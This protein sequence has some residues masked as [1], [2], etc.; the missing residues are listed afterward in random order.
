MS[1]SYIQSGQFTKVVSAITG[2]TLFR[3]DSSDKFLLSPES[4]LARLRAVCNREVL[5]WTCEEYWPKLS[6]TPYGTACNRL[7]GI[8]SKPEFIDGFNGLIEMIVAN[9]VRDSKLMTKTGLKRRVVELS[10]ALWEAGQM[11]LPPQWKFGDGDRMAV[12]LNRLRLGKEF[13]WIFEIERASRATTVQSRRRAALNVWRLGT[14]AAGVREVGD[15]LPMTVRLDAISGSRGLAAASIIPLLIVQR[16]IYGDSATFKDHDWG[17]GRGKHR[18]HSDFSRLAGGDEAL[19]EWRSIFEAWFGGE[20]TSGLEAKRSALSTFFRYLLA[21]AQVTRNP[22]EFVSRTYI[23]PVPFEAWIDDQGYEEGTSA[24]RIGQVA[25]FF[26]WYVDTHLA[27]EDDFGR[28]VRNPS[29][30]NPIARRKEA[31]KRAET[32]REALPIR[33][34]RELIHIITENDYAWAK[35][36]KEDY[37]SRYDTETQ[38]WKLFWCPV[39]AYALLIKLY[40]PLRTFQV[41]MLDSG[42]GDSVL[43][44]DG[45]WEKNT[46]DLA[47]HGRRSVQRGFLRQFKDNGT[48]GEFV[49]FYVN[50][51]K[52]ADRFKDADARGYEMPW[53]HDEVITLV[54]DLAAWQVKYNPLNKPTRWSDVTLPSVR[55]SYTPTQLAARGEACFLF[56]DPK[57]GDSFLPVQPG[58]I[59]Q[60]WYKLMDELERRVA[61]RGE[62]LP[63][64]HPIRFIEKRGETGLPMV[65][66][67]DLHSL[68]VSILTAL[69]VEGAVP[70]SVL[71]KCVAGHA[72][73][74]MTLYY[75][76]QGP[77]YIS[78][79]LAEAQARIQAKEQENFVRFLQD[80]DLKNVDSVVAY[81]DRVALDSISGRNATGWMVDDLGICPVGGSL[82]HQGGPKLTGENGRIDFQPTPG[83]P[84]NCVRCRFFLSGP[85]FL[86]G[87]VAHFNSIGVELMESSDRLRK[88]DADIGSI[89]DVMYAP[90]QHLAH[91]RIKLDALYGRRE[92]AMSEL[93]DVA[94]NW[95]AT[96]ML[97]ERSRSLLEKER[98]QA[99]CQGTVRLVA[100]GEESDI[101]TALVESSSFALY[102]SV[103]QHA[104]IYPARSAPIAI[105][106]RG[107]L[108][109]AMLARNDKQ[110]IFS[111]LT[112]DE[113]LLVGNAMVAFLRARIGERETERL[114]AGTRMLESAGLG[115]DLD[116]MLVSQLGVP[117]KLLAVRGKKSVGNESKGCPE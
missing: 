28:P 13:S 72:S 35:G 75:L 9:H 30:F 12:E 44:R 36:F 23:C 6:G 39:R 65:A 111:S 107:R 109:D 106:R 46:T 40:L 18:A 95:H 100:G 115:P 49:G 90:G 16:Q 71:S 74:L 116:V 60:Y 3:N 43:Y 25:G 85:A 37:L 83:G 87:L 81:N 26:D 33:Y 45:L 101:A 92:L 21:C 79:Q 94:N 97:I 52:T 91:D 93:D 113:A 42:E 22:L 80:C 50:T 61:A 70:L 31:P 76:K 55:R 4:T 104:T 86:G 78:Q 103:C 11:A 108:L 53:Q 59:Q 7:V 114:I 63:N 73:V 105:L 84:R 1:E 14:T 20:V 69:S 62:T 102:D 96:Y 58:R 34:L 68:R 117:A 89:E 27:L 32:A 110:P 56:R 17:V 41:L 99:G 47:P 8:K 51:N 112:D 77:A 29:L 38:Q 88:M 19:S 10:S 2:R 82:C 24:K 57:R 15:I 98:D 67:F 5:R 66:V 48:G 64:G 54:S